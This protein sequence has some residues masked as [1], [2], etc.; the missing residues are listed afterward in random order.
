MPP[1]QKGP[2]P[3]LR[4]AEP[5]SA[6]SLVVAEQQFAPTN[7][8]QGGSGSRY[9]SSQGQPL[10]LWYGAHSSPTPWNVGQGEAKDASEK[11]MIDNSSFPMML[12]DKKPIRMGSI[13]AG[14]LRR[15]RPRSVEHARPKNHGSCQF[16]GL[17]TAYVACLTRFASSSTSKWSLADKIV[18][19]EHTYREIH[20]FLHLDEARRANASDDSSPDNERDNEI[21]GAE[22][23]PH[24]APNPSPTSPTP[25]SSGASVMT[26]TSKN[27]SH[28]RLRPISGLMSVRFD[29]ADLCLAPSSRWPTWS[30]LITGVFALCAGLNLYVDGTIPERDP[31][32][33]PVAH[34]NWQMND[35]SARAFISMHIDPAK[36]MAISSLLASPSSVVRS[37]LMDRHEKLCAVSS[38]HISLLLDGLQMVNDAASSELEATAAELSTLANRISKV[39]ELSG[40]TVELLPHINALRDPA[41]DG[42]RE[43]LTQEIARA[44]AIK[45]G[46]EE[47]E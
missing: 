31:K 27:P 29:H 43:S 5:N 10:C 23:D 38:S 9:A 42:L 41:F 34:L 17:T 22:E 16:S 12:C 46:K 36:N 13:F 26:P 14:L 2:A 11:I 40:T 4:M 21:S 35:G 8:E 25:K 28:P 1:Q 20:Q 30:P 7:W 32:V 47:K 37:A 39:G 33:E 45:D 19:L 44:P 15:S 18:R 6:P 3:P 24:P